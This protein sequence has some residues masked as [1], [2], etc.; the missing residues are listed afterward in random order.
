MKD[1]HKKYIDRAVSIYANRKWKEEKIKY[2]SKGTIALMI[3]MFFERI[4]IFNYMLLIILSS[5]VAYIYMQDTTSVKVL[6]AIYMDNIYMTEK[7]RGKVKS[8]LIADSLVRDEVNYLMTFKNVKFTNYEEDGSINTIKAD[9][10]LQYTKS[11]NMFFEGDVFL[12]SE[13]YKMK[14]GKKIEK[15]MNV[16]RFYSQ[17]LDYNYGQ[18]I[19]TSNKPVRIYKGRNI[20][21]SGDKMWTNTRNDRT[22]VT[23]NVKITIYNKEEE[24]WI[25]YIYHQYYL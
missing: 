8:I 2:Q 22:R 12:R 6:K 17:K 13:Y 10:A 14:N 1:K 4:S 15:N 11:K 5:Y 7:N 16:D 18:K 3:E 19:L 24:I 25:S 21:V 9:H 20:V 23:G